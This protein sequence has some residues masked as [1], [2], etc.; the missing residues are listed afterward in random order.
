MVMVC[1]GL[2]NTPEIVTDLASTLKEGVCLECVNVKAKGVY[3]VKYP[4]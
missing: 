2:R 1:P 4:L 3:K